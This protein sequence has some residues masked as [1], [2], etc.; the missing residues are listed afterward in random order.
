M[1]KQWIRDSVCFV[2]VILLSFRRHSL[3]IPLM[4][5]QAELTW[6]LDSQKRNGLPARRWLPISAVT[7][8]D[9]RLRQL[10]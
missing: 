5:G 2:T 8:L 7:G 1:V 3:S 10:R 6:I 9:V 4:D